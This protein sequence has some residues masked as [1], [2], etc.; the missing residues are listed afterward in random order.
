M[1]WT[2]EQK[3]FVVEEYLSKQLNCN[4]MNGSDVVNFLS[5]QWST[6]GSTSSETM[7]LCITSIVK[8]QTDNRTLD[9]RNH[10]G[11]HTTLLLSETLLSTAHASLCV[12]EVRSLESTG[13]PCGEFWSHI[14]TRILTGYRLN[15][16]LHLTTWGSKWSCASGFA[17][18]LTL[19]QTF[20]TM[21]S[22]WTRRI[23]CCQVTWTLRTTSSGVAHP[24]SSVCKGHYTLW[25]ELPGLPSPNMASLD[26]SGLRM[27][28]STLWQSTLSDI[29]RCLASSGQH[30]VDEE[31]SSGS[32]SG[33]SRMVPLPTPQTN[34][35]HGYSSVSLT[36]WS[37]TGVTR[38][39]RRI[40]WTWT[41]Q[42]FICGDTLRKGCTDY[43]W[44]EGSNHSSNKSDPKGG[45]REGHQELYLPDPNVPAAPGSSFGAHFLS[46]SETKSFCS[47]DLKLWR[48]LLHRLDLT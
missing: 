24:L 16:S 12:G 30:L 44:P 46:S 35:W 8:T 7:G 36:D 34:H 28:T 10:Q 18:R 2:T 15:K 45:M 37:A 11:H 1:P 26:C 19:C 21:S 40:H 23:F 14:S 25:S 38:S 41:P 27:T 3:I 48:C 17:T 42:I 33:S 13:S 22:F 31:G 29:S 5:T 20:L 47:T 39:G 32:S 6:D 9:D 43:P 4:S